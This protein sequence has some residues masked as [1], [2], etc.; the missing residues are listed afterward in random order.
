M[1]RRDFELIAA[2]FAE[3]EQIVHTSEP[4]LAGVVIVAMRVAAKLA[5]TNERFSQER[6]LAACFPLTQR[7]VPS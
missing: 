1:T 7:G 2:G 3:A 4:G 6:F 5:A